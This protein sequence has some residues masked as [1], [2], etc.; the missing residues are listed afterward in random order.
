MTRRSR[1]RGPPILIL[2]G[3]LALVLGLSA[4]SSGVPSHGRVP[5]ASGGV[6]QHEWHAVFA[7][8][9][10]LVANERDVSSHPA[11][12]SPDW[13]VTS[14]SLFADAGDGWTGPID[15]RTPDLHSLRSTGSAVFRVVTRRLF[16]ACAVAFDLRLDLRTTTPRTPARAFDGVHVFLRYLDPWNLYVVSVARRDGLVVVKRKEMPATSSDAALPEDAG[17]V[18]LA[19]AYAPYPLHVWRHVVVT[20]A[21]VGTGVRLTLTVDGRLLL[22]T[23]DHGSPAQPPLTHPGRVGLRGDNT[24]FHF[25]DLVVTPLQ[26]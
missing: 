26:P 15:G 23:V 9:R 16:P 17:Y 10:S 14:G 1:R 21:D 24:G 11:A 7:A 2:A 4:C 25:R 13:I 3:G 6:D 20:V 8:G 18:T 5:A 22:D 12:R 19:S